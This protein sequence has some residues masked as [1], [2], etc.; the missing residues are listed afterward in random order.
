MSDIKLTKM[1]FKH[2]Y[3]VWVD[4]CHVGMVAKV[5]SKW[6]FK[7]RSESAMTPCRPVANTRAE[8]VQRLL[9]AMHYPLCVVC[10]CR[11]VGDYLSNPT[12][13]VVCK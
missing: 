3:Y 10:E 4:N 12:R 7:L 5:T 9:A 6:G 11:I 1:H 13:H 8:A 2:A